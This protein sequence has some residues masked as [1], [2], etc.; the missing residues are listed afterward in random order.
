MAAPGVSTLACVLSLKRQHEGFI[1]G[2]SLPERETLRFQLSRL[3][4]L[5]KTSFHLH[6]DTAA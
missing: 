3:G 6:I 4:Q 2:A 1:L 5:G